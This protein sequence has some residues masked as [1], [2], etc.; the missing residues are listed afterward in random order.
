MGQN[1]IL[2]LNLINNPQH[3]N[4]LIIYKNQLFISNFLFLHSILIL[5]SQPNLIIFYSEKPLI[6]I[7]LSLILLLNTPFPILIALVR[8]IIKLPFQ[9]RDQ[10]QLLLISFQQ[11]LVVLFQGQQ[12]RM[13]HMHQLQPLSI[14]LN[15][16]QP[17]RH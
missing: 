5:I 11:F 14:N 13:L 4:L 17:Q 10:I 16:L 6:P 9:F 15:Y 1:K 7:N 12:L 3:S 2:F 8:P